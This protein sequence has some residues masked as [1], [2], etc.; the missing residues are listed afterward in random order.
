MKTST[1]LGCAIAL[2]ML[3]AGYFYF[4]PTPWLEKWFPSLDEKRSA[5]SQA[6]S[7]ATPVPTPFLVPLPTAKP[8]S[9]RCA[10]CAGKGYK[11]CAAPTCRHGRV[12]CPDKC[13]KLSEGHWERMTVAGHPPNEL[14]QKFYF[15]GGWTAV[16]ETQCGHIIEVEN[17]EIVDFGACPT[18]KGTTEVACPVCQGTG[19]IECMACKG[20]GQAAEG[21]VS[22]P[23]P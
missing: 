4:V 18:C 17:K 21:T 20:T 2:G 6:V 11:A 3:L 7:I 16:S 22:S 14:W 8:S 12:P 19:E 5:V 1:L 15:A 23:A 9:F 10:E 13:L